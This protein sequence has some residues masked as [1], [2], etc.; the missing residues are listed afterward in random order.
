MGFLRAKIQNRAIVLKALIDSG[1]LF[2]DLISEDLANK[3]KLPITGKVK[4]VGTASTNG[5]VTIL[6]KAK[7]FKVYLEGIRDAVTI[8][9]YVV[10]DLAHPLNLGQAF[11]RTN[12]ADMSFRPE[13]IQ[14]RIKDSACLLTSSDTPLTRSSIDTRI[15]IILETLKDQGGNPLSGN[16][17]VLDLRVQQVNAVPSEMPGVSYGEKKKTITWSSTRTR[18]CNVQKTCMKPG[19]VTVVN[20]SRGNSNK[21]VQP[22]K[23]TENTVH[24][25][26][27]YDNKFMNKNMLFV[28]PGTYHRVGNEVKVLISNFGEKEVQLPVDLNLGHIAEADGQIEAEL[29]LLDH[30][31]QE[32]LSDAELVERRSYIIQQLKLDEN[33]ILNKKPEVKEE[34][35]QIFMDNWDAVSVN[36]ADYGKTNLMRFHIDIP[37]GTKPVRSK[38]RP[39]NPMQEQDL[40][41][42]IDDWL[43]A[44]VIEPALS[45]WASALVPCKK[46]NSDKLRWAVDYRAVNDLTVKDAYPLAHIESNLHKL[47]DTGF[48]TTLDSAGAFHTLPIHEEHRDYTAFNTPFG[49]YRFCRLPFGLANAPAAYSRLVQ[50]ALDRLPPGFA[51]GYIDDIVIYSKTLEEHVDH[52]RQVIALHVQCGMKL[53]LKKCHLIQPEVEYLGHLVST[54]GVRMI[55]SY[56]QRILDWPLPTTGKELRSFLGFCG[57]YRSFIKDFADLTYEMNKMKT[58]TQLEWTE[59]TKD[60]FERLK[61]CFK[62]GPLRG[63]PQYMN[64]EPFILDTDFSATNMAAVLS[65]KQNG[66]EVFLGCVAKKC[67]KPESNYPSHKGEMGAVVLGLKKFEHILR[68]KPFIIR[69]DSQCV[70]FMQTMKEFRGIW[71]RWQCFLASFKFTLEHRAGTKQTNADALSRM[72]GIPEPAEADPLE[73]NEPLHDVDDIYHVHPSPQV[74]EIRMEDLQ[75]ALADD[76]VTSII[77]KFVKS[78]RK[79]DKEQRKPLSSTGMSYVNVFECLQEED[80]ILYY[81][82]PTLNGMIPPRRTCLPVKLYELAFLMCHSDPSGTSGHYG[83]NSTYRKM[84]SRFYFPQMY[85]YISAKI[86]NCVPCVTKRSTLPKAEHAQHR[87]QLSYF[88]QRVYCDIVGPLTPA[89]YQGKQCKYFLTVQDGFTRYLIAT[90][91]ED[92]LTSTVVDAIITKWIHV[93]GVMETLHSDNGVNYTSHL[94]KEVM[95]K[96]GVTKT[97]TPVYSPQGDRVERAHR[98]LGDI[99][100]SDRRFEAKQWPQKLSAALLAYNATVNRLTGLSPYEAV[101]GRPVNLPVDLVFPFKHKDCMSW[102]NYLENFKLKFSQI[103]ERMC[104]AQKSGIMRDTARFQ[105][106]SKPVFKIGD[107]CY[108]FLARVKRGLSRKLQSR[109]IGPWTVKRVISESLVV[110][111][112]LGTWCEHPKEVSAIVNRLRKVDPQLSMSVTHPSRRQRI[113]LEVISDDLDEFSEYLSYQDDF[114]DE[115]QPFNPG[116]QAPLPLLGPAVG[117]PAELP[118][119]PPQ[120]QENNNLDSEP[121]PDPEESKYAVGQHIPPPEID[122]HLDTSTEAESYSSSMATNRQG[123]IARK[124]SQIAARLIHKNIT[125]PYGPEPTDLD[126]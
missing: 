105:A 74:K 88:G 81:Q 113:D 34:V 54:D 80:G 56:V 63:Y 117:S 60:K 43:E 66:K 5:K 8:N 72:P 53:N 96:L 13:G 35:I 46:K 86:N 123:R 55:P 77:L 108:Y 78:H 7:S 93:H 71:A 57:Y 37:K 94:F 121:I 125:N 69:T 76:P 109:W 110:I 9:P 120:D 112:P 29:N 16:D 122:H 26:P 14:I 116:P 73:P 38:I 59:A 49:Q 99:L 89:L 103:C 87:E 126:S 102:S 51:L 24:L 111:Y 28:H 67:S 68:A 64:P 97:Y 11:L 30:K 33:S 119:N 4:T 114:E 92:Q 31:P 82:P 48:F 124:A 19:T 98:I 3:L 95:L 107:A 6:G 15:K 104:K 20:L 90:P 23:E 70:K 44:E 100:R 18:V 36:D 47:T 12:N 83:M 58:G 61:I 91:L 1:N 52:L 79:P 101:Y 32:L 40:K 106:R 42:Q 50:M 75:K 2:A 84:R 21:T 85:H 25:F 39:L 118:A 65:Q 41:R 17:D 10:R 45:P 27:K 22:L 115:D 62:D